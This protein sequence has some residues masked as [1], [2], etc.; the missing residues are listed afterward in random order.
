MRAPKPPPP[1]LAAPGH[2]PRPASSSRFRLPGR[3]LPPELRPGTLPTSW[4]RGREG[5]FALSTQPHPRFVGGDRG[6]WPAPQVFARRRATVSVLPYFGGRPV[7]QRLRGVRS[8]SSWIQAQWGRRGR[9]ELGRGGGLSLP[10]RPERSG[11]GARRDKPHLRDSGSQATSSRPPPLRGGGEREVLLA[12]YERQADLAGG[13]V[14]IGIHKDNR[15]PCAEGETALDH[16]NGR[17][18]GDEARHHVVGAVTR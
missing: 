7:G 9:A 5:V 13:V 3:P 15:L 17:A 12:G 2:P 16:R 8:T 4:W 14:L 10:A 18:R 11:E 6:L 1:A